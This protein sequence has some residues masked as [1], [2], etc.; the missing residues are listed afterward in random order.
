MTITPSV[1]TPQTKGQRWTIDEPGSS[2]MRAKWT[3]TAMPAHSTYLLMPKYM[4]PMTAMLLRAN[5]MIV[6]PM[7][8]AS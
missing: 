2:V 7:R 4:R 1:E 8:C 6:L 5:G 3:T